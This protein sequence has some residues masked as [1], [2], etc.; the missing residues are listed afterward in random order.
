MDNWAGGTPHCH[1]YPSEKTEEQSEVLFTLFEW[2]LYGNCVCTVLLTVELVVNDLYYLVTSHKELRHILNIRW[3]STVFESTDCISL[4]LCWIDHANKLKNY[5]R[6]FGSQVC[7]GA[8][9]DFSS[10]QNFVRIRSQIRKSVPYSQ[11]FRDGVKNLGA[12][13]SRSR[14]Q[15]R[16]YQSQIRESIP[17]WIFLGP[18]FANMEFSCWKCTSNWE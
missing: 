7:E 17:D 5:L 11:F 13:C 8:N 18:T 3:D 15:I 9:P 10:S 16:K 4:I 2:C 12:G 6:H 14:S 1:L